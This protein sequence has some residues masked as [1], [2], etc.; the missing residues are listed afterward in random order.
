MVVR[1][2]RQLKGGGSLGSHPKKGLGASVTVVLSS[3]MG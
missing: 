1:A 3:V 2:R